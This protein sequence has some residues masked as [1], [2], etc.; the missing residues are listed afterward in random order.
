MLFKKIVIAVD[1]D[2]SSWPTLE[3]IREIGLPREAEVHL[4]HAFEVAPVAYDFLASYL[5]TEIEKKEI[6]QVIET[7]LTTL[8]E[9]LGLKNQS[10]VKCQCLVSGNARQDFLNYVEKLGCDLI[11]TASQEKTL[12]RGIFEGSFASYL[13]KYARPNLLVLRPA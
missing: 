13:N 6:Q 7:K 2:E 4:V 3:K 9:R 5:P 12:M 11:I 1:L 8:I 10:K